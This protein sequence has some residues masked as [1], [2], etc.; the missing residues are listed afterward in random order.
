[1]IFGGGAAGI[2]AAQAELENPHS[3]TA[4]M[5]ALSALAQIEC[6]ERETELARFHERHAGEHLLIDKWLSLNA[7]CVGKGAAARV[8]ALTEHADFRWTT[9]NKVY[10]LIAGFSTGNT[11]G[12]N[13]ADGAG[14]R[15]VAD[16][17]LR[18][19]RTN[20]QVAARIATGFRSFRVLDLPR[21]TA[22]EA[23]LARVLAAPDLSRDVYEIISRI[24]DAS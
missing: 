8:A 2:A 12:F 4:E 13:A 14:Y 19:N 10:A 7:Q 3:M 9:P 15:L 21:R 5:T 17:I 23:E 6:A 16:A 24:L 22:A 18:L 1:M 20:P 11:A